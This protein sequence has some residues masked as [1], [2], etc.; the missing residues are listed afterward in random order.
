M[1]KTYSKTRILVECA[2][3]IAA[4]T[5][6]SNI[7]IYELP[8]GGRHLFEHAAFR[9]GQLPAAGGFVNSLLQM[10]LGLCR[11]YFLGS[12]YVLRWPCCPS[13]LAWPSAPFGLFLQR[14]PGL[15]GT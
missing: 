7:K 4:G 15:L 2:L 14:R 12:F 8:N 6:L 5:V 11:L 9:A 13:G 1:T 10:L 3:M